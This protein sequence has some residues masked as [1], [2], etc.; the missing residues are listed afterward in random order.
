MKQL[1]L[2]VALL[3][4]AW[5]AGA[6]TLSLNLSGGKLISCTGGEV[7]HNV[8]LGAVPTPS[9]SVYWME[10]K[11]S[12]E[13]YD[14]ATVRLSG[15]EGGFTARSFALS[16]RADEKYHY[17]SSAAAPVIADGKATL[18]FDL[19]KTHRRNI[20]AVRLFFNRDNA[21]KP[22]CSFTIDSIVFS[23]T[24]AP[25]APKNTA[26][27]P[28]IELEKAKLISCDTPQKLQ[29]IP[30]GVV[31]TVPQESGAVLIP[32]QGDLS[33]ISGLRV[34]LGGVRGNFSASSFAAAFR[35]GSKYE[36]ARYA[37]APKFGGAQAELLFDMRELAEL[38]PELLRL[39]F[40]RD[41][42]ITGRVGFKIESVE[43]VRGPLPA[44]KKGPAGPMVAKLPLQKHHRLTD[45]TYIFPR[46][47]IKYSLFMN[48]YAAAHRDIWLDRPLEYDRSLAG[49]SRQYDKSGNFASV[50]KDAATLLTYADG[51]G[52][53]ATSRSYLDR[54][55]KGME[56]AD[57]A[58][59]KN[60]WLL[61]ISP[62]LTNLS[63]MS[64]DGD[65]SFIYELVA[66]AVKS[67]SVFRID[68]NIVISSYNANGIPPEKWAPVVAEMKKTADGKLLFIAEIRPPFFAAASEYSRNGKKVST[69]TIETMKSFIRS[70]LDVADGVLF[71]GCNHIVEQTDDMSNYRFGY[72]F[73]R[74]IL[75][76][77]L[78]SVCNEPKYRG[79]Y[80]GVSGAKG[81]FYRKNAT[82]SQSEE[83]TLTLRRSLEAALEIDPDFILMPEWNEANENT[84]LQ[85]TVYDARTTARVMNHFRGKTASMDADP[86][87]PD[88]VVSY[89]REL[90]YGE[91]VDIELLNIPDA[92]MSGDTLKVGLKLRNCDGKV[93]ADL[94]ET[95]L[96]A[97]TLSEKRFKLPSEKFLDER[98]LIPELRWEMGGK[99]GK[100]EGLAAILLE[101][102]PTMNKL[103]VNQPLRD[104]CLLTENTL[105]WQD[106]GRRVT[107]SG[108]L[109]G[110]AN[111]NSIELL[112]G[113][114]PVAA[115][116]LHRPPLKKGSS[117]NVIWNSVSGKGTAILTIRALKGRSEETEDDSVNMAEFL[118]SEVKIADGALE[119]VLRFTGAQNQFPVRVAP[120]SV[121]E[122]ALDGEKFTVPAADIFRYGAYR[123][124]FPDGK[125]LLLEPRECQYLVPYPVGKNNV[126]FTLEADKIDPAAVYSVRAIDADGK[127]YRSAPFYPQKLSG[128]KADIAL[129]S[130]TEKAAVRAA[131]PAEFVRTVV[132]DLS[133]NT[134]DI[135]VT[136][137]R[138]YNA[139]AGGGE[140]GSGLLR[141][142]L[143]NSAPERDFAEKALVFDGKNQVLTI[144]KLAVSEQ[145]FTLSFE[146]LPEETGEQVLFNTAYGAPVAALWCHVKDGTL[147]GAFRNRENKLFRFQTEKVVR[148]GQWNRV[149]LRY[150]LAKLTVRC[151]GNVAAQVPACGLLYKQPFLY[152]GGFDSPKSPARFRGKLRDIRISN[153]LETQQ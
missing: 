4:A 24:A 31:D 125:T 105:R 54:T 107:V 97:R 129:W 55:L 108:T 90:V 25:S 99:S 133:A 152:F 84:H 149:E 117:I 78:V 147:L 101:T 110:A 77:T 37:V 124:V 104:L 3:G 115:V 137:R 17:A 57:A 119:K 87:V 130:F 36:Y 150:D 52:I 123:K 35:R 61:E 82:G 96:D 92:R 95:V 114:A 66:A 136:Y 18:E 131:V 45:K 62:A 80:L 22:P 73:Y 65:F 111:F 19:S 138:D 86:T 23:R 91:I 81:Y 75:L 33:E 12:L 132:Y 67:P 112:A 9:G 70:Y 153:A 16:F 47:Q 89:R 72:D 44:A 7:R 2:G 100:A 6:D 10:K 39:Y 42:K 43:F 148:Y 134:G 14:R 1:L 46:T 28:V 50:R 48:Y 60:Y 141:N 142:S 79:K 27:G 11:L 146:F 51:M 30:D 41:R 121:L 88:L 59:L 113:T 56:Y 151:N 21:V 13:Q 53:L 74:N 69:A 32:V 145:S 118:R 15:M 29:P 128:K 49:G 20:L 38:R 135:L 109:A 63:K 83:G 102:P 120:D 144:P 64:G 122:I 139:L 34:R 93:L 116:D 143:Q 98:L 68:G 71:A 127:I 5:L 106:D 140:H 103:Y 94:G 85:P 76:P 26:A 8:V 58:G 126:T 40:N